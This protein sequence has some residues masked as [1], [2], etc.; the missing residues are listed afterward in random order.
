MR[1]WSTQF[2]EAHFIIFFRQ[3]FIHLNQKISQKK[4]YNIYTLFNSISIGTS[5]TTKN[6]ENITQPYDS[7]FI[8]DRFKYSIRREIRVVSGSKDNILYKKFWLQ[9]LQV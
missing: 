4:Y 1:L 7:T 3:H 6:D 9:Y 5:Q 2:Q 8:A